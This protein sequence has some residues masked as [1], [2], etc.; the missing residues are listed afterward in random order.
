MIKVEAINA[1]GHTI[2]ICP[3][4]FSD[5]PEDVE[6][7]ILV[8][9]ARLCELISN[10]AYGGPSDSDSERTTMLSV[11]RNLNLNA[12]QQRS[13]SKNKSVKPSFELIDC[14]CAR[15][16]QMPVCQCFGPD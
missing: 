3:S 1:E 2:D 9:T 6:N 12:T 11:C 5:L 14:Q 4:T 15:F 13:K 16:D 8:R 7:V 10:E